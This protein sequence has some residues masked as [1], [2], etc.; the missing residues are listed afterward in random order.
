MSNSINNVFSTNIY[1]SFQIF[2]DKF[3]DAC[4]IKTLDFDWKNS[5]IEDIE[6]T[7]VAVLQD[8]MRSF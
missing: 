4:A 1:D 5:N 2:K 6:R 3:F 7:S 8:F